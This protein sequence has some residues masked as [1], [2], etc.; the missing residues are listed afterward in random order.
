MIAGSISA[1]SFPPKKVDDGTLLLLY[2]IVVWSALALV[3]G[4]AIL[5]RKAW[6]WWLEFL[7]CA[8]PVFIY[9]PY[10]WIRGDKS[11]SSFADWV[12]L[13]GAFMMSVAAIYAINNLYKKARRETSMG[14][15]DP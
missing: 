14:T 9:L 13:V 1:G 15:Q 5:L 12:S 8:I 3:A 10:I 6:G 11:P 7:I 2:A 4:I